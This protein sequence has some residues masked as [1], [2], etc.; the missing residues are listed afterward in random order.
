VEEKDDKDIKEITK[1]KESQKTE[2]IDNPHKSEDDESETNKNNENNNQNHQNSQNINNIEKKSDVENSINTKTNIIIEVGKIS[3][4]A[5]N[6]GN[7]TYPKYELTATISEINPDYSEQKI[8]YIF[9]RMVEGTDNDYIEIARSSLPT[10]IDEPFADSEIQNLKNYK[11]NYKVIG[12]YPDGTILDSKID[13]E[14]QFEDSYSEKEKKNDSFPA[15]GI[16]LIAIF[17]VGIIA[18]ASFLVYKL[19]SKKAVE[20]VTAVVSDNAENV[21]E[22]KKFEGQTYSEV[23]SNSPRGKKRKIKS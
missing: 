2:S 11:V 16:A 5:K 12:I 8:E 18:G 13:G 10:Y 1:E 17:G 4:E 21:E 19:L 3:L 7:V 23:T 22:V 9:Y 20:N 14:N 6:I 15:Y